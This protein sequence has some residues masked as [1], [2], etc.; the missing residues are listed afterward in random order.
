MWEKLHQKS[1]RLASRAELTAKK[2]R[3]AEA[4]LLYAQAATYEFAA[5]AAYGSRAPRTTGILAVSAAAL[6]TKAG[7][8]ADALWISF[9]LLP[10]PALPKFAR[11]Q[12][13]E[14]RFFNSKPPRK[15]S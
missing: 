12:L 3:A 13:Q 10:S 9:L 7:R 5:L 8:P 15:A 1:E 2:G 14:I 4:E 6:L 11:D